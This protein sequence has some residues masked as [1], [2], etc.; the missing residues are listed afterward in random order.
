MATNRIWLRRIDSNEVT[1]IVENLNQNGFTRR[2]SG[3]RFPDLR[4]AIF[5]FFGLA[6]PTLMLAF[7]AAMVGFCLSGDIFTLFVF[8]RTDERHSLRPHHL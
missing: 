6:L 7:L 8:F 2:L 1:G 4:V 3:Y 5:R